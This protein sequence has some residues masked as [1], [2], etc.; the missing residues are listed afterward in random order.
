MVAS[1]S[2]IDGATESDQFMSLPGT[3]TADV[4]ETFLGKSVHSYLVILGGSFLYRPSDLDP[5][6]GSQDVLESTPISPSMELDPVDGKRC[7]QRV[8]FTEYS[9]ADLLLAIPQTSVVGK[10]HQVRKQQP[11]TPPEDSSCPVKGMFRLLDLITE[12]G[13]SGLGN[14]FY[15]CY[16]FLSHSQHF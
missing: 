1:E 9:S 14:F 8:M 12:Q 5:L 4:D 3:P 13:T 10:G 16:Q 11:S 6:L 15:K 7:L 2:S